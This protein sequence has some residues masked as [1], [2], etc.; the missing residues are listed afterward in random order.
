MQALC[1]S[2]RHPEHPPESLHS[3]ITQ[4]PA[5]RP[6]TQPQQLVANPEFGPC[7][8]DA[9]G[10]NRPCS[11]SSREAASSAPDCKPTCRLRPVRRRLSRFRRSSGVPA[12]HRPPGSIRYMSCAPFPESVNTGTGQPSKESPS[13]F[14]RTF[15]SAETER[16]QKACNHDKFKFVA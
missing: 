15:A 8:A 3:D 16:T 1:A 4:Y 12:R 5:V 7:G 2:C 11:S 13:R 6:E 10:W 14:S 9:Q